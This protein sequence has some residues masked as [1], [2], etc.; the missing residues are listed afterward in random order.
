MK[1]FDVIGYAIEGAFYCAAHAQLDEGDTEC[2][3]ATAVFAGD[4]GA[5]D[6]S[7]DGCVA[8]SVAAHQPA[9]LDETR[10]TA[11]RETDIPR[12]RGRRDGY[13]TLIPGAFLLQIDGKRWYRVRTTCW[14]NAGTDFIRIEGRQ[15]VLPTGWLIRWTQHELATARLRSMGAAV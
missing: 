9:Y 11:L 8:A 10:I 14:G 15:H 3:H 5:D 2:G 12:H 1:H 4:E 6:L 13:G 7:C